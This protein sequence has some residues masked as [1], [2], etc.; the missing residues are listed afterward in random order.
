M[1][2]TSWAARLNTVSR[3]KKAATPS[4]QG[5]SRGVVMA[6]VEFIENIDV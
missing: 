5:L 4:M 6:K 2:P 3:R 1:Y